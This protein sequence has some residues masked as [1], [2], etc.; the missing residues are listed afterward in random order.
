M[1]FDVL[2]GNH[3]F[4]PGGQDATAASFNQYFGVSRLTGRNHY[5]GH[6]GSNNSNDYQLFSAGG[7]DFIL[8][9]LAY[10]SVADPAVLAWADGLLETYPDRGRSST[11]TGSSAPATRRASA[12]RVRPSTTA[13]KT[14][15]TSSI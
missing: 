3:D 10:R 11:A 9:N 14:T 1:P 5:G 2:P 4:L 12:D 7:M 6:Y 8:V 15:A 13:S